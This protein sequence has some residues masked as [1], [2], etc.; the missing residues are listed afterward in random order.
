V[1]KLLTFHPVNT[2]DEVFSIAL[3]PAP[4]PIATAADPTLM[5]QMEA[6]TTGRSRPAK[7]AIA[8]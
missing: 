8:S 4:I 7:P 6:P 2:L 5:E 1:R 3:M